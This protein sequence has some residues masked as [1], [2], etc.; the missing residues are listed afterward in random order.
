MAANIEHT[1]TGDRE[2]PG[3]RYGRLTVRF[4]PEGLYFREKGSSKEWGPLPWHTGYE[5]ALK[6]E[7]RK[8]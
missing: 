1:R 4:A 3:G 7:A 8:V 2:V 5:V 6:M